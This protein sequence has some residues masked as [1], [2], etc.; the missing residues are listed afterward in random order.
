MRTFFLNHLIKKLFRTLSK[1]FAVLSKLHST[2]PEGHFWQK[3]FFGKIHFFLILSKTFSAGLLKLDA[4][5]PEEH[6]GF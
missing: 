4:T 6:F 2:Y 5:C 1:N 3:Q